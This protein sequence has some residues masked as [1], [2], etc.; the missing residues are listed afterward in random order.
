[1]AIWVSNGDGT[2]QGHFRVACW[3]VPRP[4]GGSNDGSSGTLVVVVISACEP[5]EGVP[6]FL[7]PVFSLMWG[8][9]FL[10]GV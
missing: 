8:L 6:P 7:N 9:I 1:M 2:A 4:T 5:E 10:I 3:M